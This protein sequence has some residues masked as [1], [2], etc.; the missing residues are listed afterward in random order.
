MNRQLGF[1]LIGDV[2]SPYMMILFCL[3]WI[4]GIG[5]AESIAIVSGCSVLMIISSGEA[6]LATC[7]RYITIISS[8]MCFEYMLCRSLCQYVVYIL[9]NCKI[10]IDKYN[11]FCI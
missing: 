10:Y 7:T 3:L 11:S 1:G 9:M 4:L 8:D 2:S 6:F 5:I